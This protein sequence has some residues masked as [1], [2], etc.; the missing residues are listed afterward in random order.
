VVSLEDG[1][2]SASP[3]KTQF[4]WHVILREDSRRIEPP[5]FEEAKGPLTAEL[6]RKRAEE[7]VTAIRDKSEIELKEPPVSSTE[8]E[9]T[10]TE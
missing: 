4:G 5:S 1:K 2:Y 9:V 6:R 7:Y 8:D 3:V 10:S